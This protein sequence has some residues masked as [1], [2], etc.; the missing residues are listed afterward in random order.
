[1]VDIGT[2]AA[3]RLGREDLYHGEAEIGG[4]QTDFWSHHTLAG[5]EHLLRGGERRLRFHLDRNAA[6]S[7]HVPRRLEDDLGLPRRYSDPLHSRP[8]PH[9][10]RHSKNP[11]PPPP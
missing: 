4:G 2:A 8:R 7:P 1:M 3:E 6:K 10:T 9:A 11:P 5:P